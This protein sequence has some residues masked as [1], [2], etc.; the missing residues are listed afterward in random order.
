MMMNVVVADV[1]VGAPPAREYKAG[2]LERTVVEMIECA[3]STERIHD[4]MT[5]TFPPN[6]YF[7]FNPV[8][9]RYNVDL[10]ESSKL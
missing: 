3:T 6:I 7:R 10:D 8:D 9:E 1:V 5:D 4:L 2:F